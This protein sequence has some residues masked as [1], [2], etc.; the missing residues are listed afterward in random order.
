MDLFENTFFLEAHRKI[1]PDLAFKAA[2]CD[3]DHFI[4]IWATAVRS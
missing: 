4:L 2:D 1:K 3:L